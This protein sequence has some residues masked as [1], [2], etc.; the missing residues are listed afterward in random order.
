MTALNKIIE[1]KLKINTNSKVLFFRL[2]TQEWLRQTKRDEILQ[3]TKRKGNLL[4]R[5]ERL[6]IEAP[7]NKLL[8]ELQGDSS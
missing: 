4:T 2:V 7:Y 6:L 5:M 3:A 1:E 8:D